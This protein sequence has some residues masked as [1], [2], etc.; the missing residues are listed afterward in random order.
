LPKPVLR[1]YCITHIDVISTLIAVTG[2][3]QLHNA[4][5]VGGCAARS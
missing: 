5:L 3:P 2:I 1:K 4:M